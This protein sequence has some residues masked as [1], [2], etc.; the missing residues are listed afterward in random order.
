MNCIFVGTER[1][2]G[3]YNTTSTSNDANKTID[4]CLLSGCTKERSIVHSVLYLTDDKYGNPMTN[5]LVRAEKFVQNIR[6][7]F[8]TGELFDIVK[9]WVQDNLGKTIVI[10]D[11]DL[12]ESFILNDPTCIYLI[13]NKSGYH[14]I[15]I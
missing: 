13:K 4:I 9:A 12:V 6:K 5:K 1:F 8:Q 10:I 11:I 14:P 7:I 3:K 2:I 15:I